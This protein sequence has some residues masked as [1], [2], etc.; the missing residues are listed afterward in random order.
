MKRFFVILV[1]ILG[2]AAFTRSIEAVN[3][4]FIFGFDQG[5]HWLAAKSIIIDHKVPLI[6]DEVGGGGGFFQGSGW[7]YLLAIPFFLFQGNPYG[8]IIL[9]VTVGLSTVALTFTLFTKRFGLFTGTCVS[10]FIAISPAISI[11][12]RF[13]WPPFVI[14]F[15]TVCFL[16][17]W[18]KVLEGNS[19]A[20]FFLFFILSLFA[21]FEIATAATFGVAI[22]ILLP[23]FVKVKGKSILYGIAGGIL[24]LLPLLVFDLRHQFLN[25]RGI[26]HMLIGSSSGQPWML[27][28]IF[29]NH[30]AVFLTNLFGT[31]T[32]FPWRM[33]LIVLSGFSLTL[34]LLDKRKNGT[35]KK[36]LLS[37][38]LVPCLLFAMLLGYKQML[39]EWWLLELPIMYC[40]IWGILLS[41]VGKTNFLG[42][43]VSIGILLYFIVSSVQFSYRGWQTDLYDYGGTKKIKGETEAVE[44]IFDDAKGKPFGVL[45]FTPP[46]YTYQYDF[47]FWY[48]GTKKYHY[49]PYQEKKG[50]FYLLIEPDEGKMWSYEGWLTTVVKTGTT[51]SRRE[52]PS[53]FIIERRVAQ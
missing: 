12:S 35:E 5:K 26:S 38:F 14:P 46:V 51:I 3:G 24:P 43:I 30:S 41:Y 34:F 39:W 20:W 25:I 33:L 31:F 22:L 52:L 36:F 47:L 17:Y 32:P 16:H 18:Y 9:M 48:I 1:F 7:Y 13:A 50:T 19:R 11:Q 44:A 6:G 23:F 40:V 37:L 42:K 2:I 21:H 8:S 29:E 15:L 49:V 27:S 28:K 45:V 4:N 53:G 10:L